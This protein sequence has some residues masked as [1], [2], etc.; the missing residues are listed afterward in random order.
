MKVP[1]KNLVY[2]TVFFFTTKEGELFQYKRK[3]NGW[4]APNCGEHFG[5]QVT[6]K[7]NSVTVIKC[8]PFLGGQYQ[9]Q[10]DVWFT[11]TTVV[12]V[13]NNAIML[14]A[15][16]IIADRKR[17]AKLEAK[18]VEAGICYKCGEKLIDSK[19]KNCK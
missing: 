3:S 15:R 7:N 19:C 12:D 13:T 11:E 8:L 18:C 2:D 17:N 9:T 16:T 10:I 14:K 1:L 4:S 6:D 5:D